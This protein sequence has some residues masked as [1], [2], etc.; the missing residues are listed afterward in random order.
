LFC[1]VAKSPITVYTGNPKISTKA[2]T[3]LY[4]I[5]G[6]ALSF[7]SKTQNIKHYKWSVNG[8]VLDTM[9][10]F[11]WRPLDAGEYTILLQT[12]DLQNCHSEAPSKTFYIH[13]PQAGFAIDNLVD[14]CGQTELKVFNNAKNAEELHWYLSG[15]LVGKTAANIDAFKFELPYLGNFYLSQ[16]AYAVVYD[17]VTQVNKTCSDGFPNQEKF[18]IASPELPNSGFSTQRDVGIGWLKFIPEDTT[19]QNYLWNID[20]RMFVKKA[21]GI[22]LQSFN[23]E[24]NK[25]V[26]LTVS[27]GSCNSK[28][29]KTVWVSKS[30]IEKNDT[31]FEVYPN[32]TEN[33][34][35]ISSKRE[36]ERLE[37]FNSVGKM[38]GIYSVSE[39]SL[40]VATG[41]WP[42]GVYSFKIQI[43]GLVYTRLVI[44]E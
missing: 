6:T 3:N 27:E 24:N 41:H 20:G 11:T 30:S 1:S 28:T 31:Y 26:C 25:E 10:T 23:D 17:S 14:S 5:N 9:S 18:E 2:A 15:N 4:C 39:S 38:I 16:I 7:E 40:S 32:P 43:D 33:F 13:G 8:Q 19:A 34:I 22:L 21:P 36:I 37:I 12:V 29:C 42:P 35:S 44:K